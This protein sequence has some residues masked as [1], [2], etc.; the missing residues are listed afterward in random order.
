M[1][2]AREKINI[3]ED[4]YST[5]NFEIVTFYLKNNKSFIFRIQI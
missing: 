3:Y 1:I 4:L 5:K 2:K